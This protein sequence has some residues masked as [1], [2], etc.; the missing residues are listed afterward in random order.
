MTTAST[1]H[2]TRNGFPVASLVLGPGEMAGE[3]PYRVEETVRCG[4][5][6]EGR[7]PDTDYRLSLGDY[8]YAS[9]GRGAE[10]LWNDEAYFDNQRQRVWVVL[11]SRPADREPAPWVQRARLPVHVVPTKLSAARYEGMLAQLRGLAAGLIFDLASKML[12]SVGFAASR[13]HIS[14]RSNQIEL[15]RVEQLWEEIAPA[16]Q[17]IA[18]NPARQMGLTWQW[19]SSWGGERLRPASLAR[20]AQTGTDPR[21]RETPRPFRLL[22]GQLTETARTLEHRVLLAMLHFLEERVRDCRDSIARHQRGLEADMPWRDRAP[23]PGPSLYTTEDMPRLRRLAAAHDKAGNLLGRIRAAQQAG[24]WVGLEP[25]FGLADTPIFQHVEPY[26]R[27]LQNFRQYLHSALVILEDGFEERLKS[28]S[29]LYEQW[30]FF[31]LAAALRRAGLVCDNMDGV[32]SRSR[33]FCFTLDVDRGA[34]LLFPL[35]AG[36]TLSLR[37]EPWILPLET[38]QQQGETLFHGRREANAWS[39]D[40]VLEL[41]E[42]DGGELPASVSYL[43][44]V[45]AKYAR[46]IRPDHW[47]QTGKYLRIRA[48]RTPREPV[49]MQLWLVYPGEGQ[50]LQSRDGVIEWTDTGPDCSRTEHSEWSMTLTPLAVEDAAEVVDGW[51]SEPCAN[52]RRFVDGLLRYL[53]IGGR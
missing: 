19:R 9:V 34:R 11:E 8:K 50:D 28:T 40:I 33:R 23:G 17:S 43:V 10:A 44:V 16:L 51:I 18:D 26:R 6:V 52:A 14:T 24:P 13:G 1:F 42:A 15:R 37:Y 32:F 36:R 39:P 22:R 21:R 4:F 31:Q 35:A 7:E 46:S 3:Q 2:L 45:D 27:C 20:L 41:L 38:A 48:T 53:E 30:V 5:A 29:R 47:E 49:G 12:R 25:S